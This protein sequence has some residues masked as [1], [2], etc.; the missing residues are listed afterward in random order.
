[1]V[2]LTIAIGVMLDVRGPF[3]V[4]LSGDDGW[5]LH[6]YFFYFK[7][8]VHYFHQILVFFTKW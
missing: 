3:F 8:C 4:N 7:A 1:M 2:A 5:Y 6:E